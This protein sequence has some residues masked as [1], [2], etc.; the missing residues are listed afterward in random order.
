VSLVSPLSLRADEFLLRSGGRIEGE[1]L[2][3]EEQ[4]L[5][6]YRVRTRAGVV[7]H[8]NTS[9][10]SEAI[11]LS[12]ERAEYD[13]LAPTSAD[14]VEGNWSLAEWC[15]KQGLTSERQNHLRRIIELDENH[16]AARRALGYTF[17]EGKW[18]TQE[19]FRREEGY[20]YYKGRWR[21]AQ[22]IEILES[23]SKYNLAQ[24]EWLARLKRYRLN[25]NDA[26]KARAAIDAVR[27]IDDPVAVRPLAELLASER[28]R[29]VKFLYVD[30]LASINTA[31]AV[32]VLV[33]RSLQDPDEEMF[34]YCVDRLAGIKQ[35]GVTEAYVAALKD[36]SNERVNKAAA[37]L[38]RM[39]DRS[40]IS[41]LIDALVTSHASVKP[42][43]FGGDATAVS[44]NGN[45][46]SMMQN[47]GPKVQIAHVRNQHVLDTLTKLSGGS[48]FGFDQRAWRYWY[49]QE[50][51]AEQA[52]QTLG[53]RSVN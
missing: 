4:P 21:T 15:R 37:A 14:T 7:L 35:P 42:S 3:R 10:V 27:A 2:N 11:R 23:R 34:Y 40:A 31:D 33:H 5:T 17:I 50:K 32:H 20:E 38:A 29:S 24:R 8:L 53:R 45:G 22:E 28:V 49:A 9:D 16:Q 6:A 13:R 48:N 30:V 26:G 1:W 51:K 44:F 46:S 12:P 41:P 52:G 39:N 43:K 36:S 47:E 18:I 19:D 25:M